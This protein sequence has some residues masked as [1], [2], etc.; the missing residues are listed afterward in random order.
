MDRTDLFKINKFVNVVRVIV[1]SL[2]G[3]LQKQP[4]YGRYREMAGWLS[5][6]VKVESLGN[7]WV[8]DV[9]NS[10]SFGHLKSCR[11]D[12]ILVTL[13]QFKKNSVMRKG[14]KKFHDMETTLQKKGEQLSLNIQHFDFRNLLV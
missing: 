4:M 9:V 5:A 10:D 8:I 3:N 1:R 7:F 13:A 6:S 11:K 2:D 12:S 14:I